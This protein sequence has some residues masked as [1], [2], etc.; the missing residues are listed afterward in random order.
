[1]LS[2][3]LSKEACA[4]CRF[5]CAFRRQSLWETPLFPMDTVKKWEAAGYGFT[6]EKSGEEYGRMKLSDRYLTADPEEEVPCYFL[7]GEKGC[8]LDVEEKPFDC[9][10]WPLR[11]MKKENKELVIALT[12]TCPEMGK[13]PSEALKKLVEEGLGEEIY[14]YALQ[15][16]FVV[17]DYKEGF[18]ILM[19]RPAAD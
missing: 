7:D 9:K 17:K 19:S 18:P 6:Q 2:S 10:I 13:T 12:P 3:V 14:R 11:I 4:K 8:V 15:H 1:M 5:C 16:P